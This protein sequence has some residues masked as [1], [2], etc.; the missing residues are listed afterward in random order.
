MLNCGA[1]RAQWNHVNL[2][3]P[4]CGVRV[5]PCLL[6]LLG[7]IDGLAATISP[8]FALVMLVLIFVILLF[9]VFLYALYSHKVQIILFVLALPMKRGHWALFA[10]LGVESLIGAL[11]AIGVSS[12]SIVH[13]TGMTLIQTSGLDLVGFVAHRLL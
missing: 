6:F 13:L 7:Q 4:I 10:G 9:R 11:P 2:I 8:M 1:L 5:L 12:L 3:L